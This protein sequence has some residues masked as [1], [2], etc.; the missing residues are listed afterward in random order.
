M[1]T[2]ELAEAGEAWSP[3]VPIPPDAGDPPLVECGD[4]AGEGGVCPLPPSMCIGAWLAYWSNGR[5]V[6]RVCFFDAKYL[7]CPSGCFQGACYTPHPTM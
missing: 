5:C 1:D 6:G 3:W 2:P 4:D 7:Y